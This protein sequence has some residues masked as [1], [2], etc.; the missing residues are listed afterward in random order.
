MRRLFYLFTVLLFLPFPSVFGN[1]LIR[2]ETN[3][4]LTVVDADGSEVV[5]TKNPD[6]VI[7]PHTSLLGLW[8][9]AGGKAVGRPESMGHGIPEEAA[10]LPVTGTVTYPNIEI[11]IS[12]E[13]ELVILGNLNT[14]REQAEILTSIG[15]ECLLLGYDNYSDFVNI[16]DVFTRLTGKE[17]VVESIIQ[18]VEKEVQAVR[19]D[20][21]GEPAPS[22]LSLFA[23]TR[24]ISAELNEA[25]TAYIAYLLGGKNIAEKLAGHIGTKRVPLSFERIVE[26][27][28]DVILVT[29]M[30]DLSKVESY[31]KNN[32]ISSRVWSGLTAVR[33]G[34][35]YYLPDEL[36]LY[37]PNERFPEAFQYLARILYGDR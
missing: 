21:Q 32:L 13:P 17:E 20:H 6:R 24:S 27:D 5:V 18:K 1:P 25:H 2:A 3:G 30:T 22:F 9:L 28:P 23:S 35:V 15:V 4:T 7:I 26:Q 16:L 14:H 19:D 34:R 12:L 37:R 11:I 33:E 10:S 31:L 8:Y 36:F 29:P